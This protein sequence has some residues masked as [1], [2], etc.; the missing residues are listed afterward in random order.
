MGQFRELVEEYARSFTTMMVLRVRY[1]ELT[2]AELVLTHKL[3]EHR[4]DLRKMA[5]YLAI[6]LRDFPPPSVPERAKAI[7]RP[8]LSKIDLANGKVGYA[9]PDGTFHYFDWR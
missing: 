8:F 3:D 2:D 7:V 1:G 9:H 6:F 4:G 5:H